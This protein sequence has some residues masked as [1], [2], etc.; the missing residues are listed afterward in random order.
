MVKKLRRINMLKHKSLVL[1]AGLAIGG[2]AT[3]DLTAAPIPKTAG[4]WAATASMNTVRYAHTAT[5]LPN[6]KVA[7]SGRIQRQRLFNRE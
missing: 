7:N 5:R 2:N 3:T 4:Q 1:L 6:D